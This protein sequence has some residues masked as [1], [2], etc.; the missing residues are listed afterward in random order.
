[1]SSEKQKAKIRQDVA[2]IYEKAFVKDEKEG[3][4][5]CGERGRLT[6]GKERRRKV[7]FRRI[8]NS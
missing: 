1:M 3:R 8:F 6:P 7:W 2:E 5:V 4:R